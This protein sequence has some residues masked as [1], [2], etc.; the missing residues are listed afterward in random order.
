MTPGGLLDAYNAGPLAKE[1]HT[2]KGTTIVFFE[3]DAFDQKDLD[4]FADTSGLP[5]FTPEVVGGLPD[6]MHGETTM[7]LQ[8]A[9]AIAPDARLVDINA[10]PTLVSDGA[11][12][13]IGRMF[14]DADRQFPGAV[15]SLSI[16]WACDKMVNAIDLAPSSL[17]WP[18][19]RPTARRP[20]TRPETTPALNARAPT[21]G[22]PRRGRM[23]L[24][25]MRS[26]RCPR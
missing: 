8:V 22:H 24:G 1:G 21:N 5:R 18:G 13:K 2:G 15:W 10:R 20:S 9:H 7:D 23:T 26:R 12:E 3:F 11:Y 16:G 25:W 14:E 6:E 4:T 19:R 17:R